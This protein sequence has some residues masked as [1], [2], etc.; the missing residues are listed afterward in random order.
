MHTHCATSLAVG[1]NKLSE[2]N[3][4]LFILFFIQHSASTH[5]YI[6]IYLLIYVGLLIYYFFIYRYFYFY[7]SALRVEWLDKYSLGPESSLRAGGPARASLWIRYKL[8]TAA[9]YKSFYVRLGVAVASVVRR[10]QRDPQMI[11]RTIC[12]SATR[13]LQQTD[14]ASRRVSRVSNLVIANGRLIFFHFSSS[15][16]KIKDH[17]TRR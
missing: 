4:L 14:S 12:K 13:G 10:D 6:Y 9:G 11:F 8:G 1:N 7:F 16:R 5:I 17:W 2:L 3:R 15:S